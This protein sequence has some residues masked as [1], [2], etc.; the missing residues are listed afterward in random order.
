MLD[1]GGDDMLSSSDIC[2]GTS[3]QCHII[4]FRSAGSNILIDEKD[5]N[6]YIGVTSSSPAYVFKFINAIYEGALAQGLTDGGD[7]LNV[8][9][10]VLI[11]S[12][13]IL[14]SSSSTA[15]EMIAKVASKGGTTERALATLDQNDFDNILT[16]AMIACTQRANEL[17]KGK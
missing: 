3:D 17:G 15:Q 14:K 5:M 1:L 8:I 2:H 9:C 12:A 4:A 7:L 16:K 6:A 10:D 11:G 13:E